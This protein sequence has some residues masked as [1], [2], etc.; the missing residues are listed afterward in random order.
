[1]NNVLILHKHWGNI[2]SD[3]FYILGSSLTLSHVALFK[4][5]NCNTVI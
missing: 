4:K 5:L 3:T 2:V 1:M